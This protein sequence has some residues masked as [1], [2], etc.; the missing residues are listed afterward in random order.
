MVANNQILA[1]NFGFSWKFWVLDNITQKLTKNGV[2]GIF[3][4][5]WGKFNI[6]ILNFDISAMNYKE[7]CQIESAK[8][9]LH[10]VHTHFDQ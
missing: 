5:G 3:L 4:G 1:L 9:E 8:G 2:L 7:K 10:P 6:F